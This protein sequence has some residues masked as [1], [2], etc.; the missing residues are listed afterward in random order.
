VLVPAIPEICT[1][2]ETLEEAR[3][4]AVDAIRCF[5]ESAVIMGE[6]P[7]PKPTIGE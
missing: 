1:Y 6:L 5:L 7:K 2:G 4:M 3:Q